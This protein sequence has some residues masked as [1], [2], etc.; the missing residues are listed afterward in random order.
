M[1]F[2]TF[3]KRTDYPKLGYIIFRLKALGIPCRFA[4]NEL[5]FLRSFHAD[6]ILEVDEASLEQADALLAEKWS[7]KGE[8]SSRGRTRLDDIP[9]DHPCF[10]PYRDESPDD[11]EEET[12][13]PIRSGWVGR[14]GRP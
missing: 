3:C 5:G 14:D 4:S 2:V 7:K 12:F 6:Y 1:N 13:D 10:F 11:G 9:D 8:P